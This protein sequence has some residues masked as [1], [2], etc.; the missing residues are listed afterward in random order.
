MPNALKLTVDTCKPQMMRQSVGEKAGNRDGEEVMKQ[1][2][3]MLLLKAKNMK[4]RDKGLQ[5]LHD[6]G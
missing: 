3:L 2:S 6:L 5:I 1:S 4:R